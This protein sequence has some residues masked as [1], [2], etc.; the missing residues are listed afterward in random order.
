MLRKTT[1]S[2]V[3]FLSTVSASAQDVS[4]NLQVTDQTEIQVLQS[5]NASIDALS[6]Q[7]MVCVEKKLA[8]PESC[9][10][11]YPAELAAVRE[12]YQA[13]ILAYPAWASRSVFWTDNSS[14][15]PVGQTMSLVNLGPQLNKCAAK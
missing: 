7:V 3:A 5:L 14:G 9:M 2:L 12:E 6:N 10:C 8:Q 4:P 15:T 11:L 1:F 13:A